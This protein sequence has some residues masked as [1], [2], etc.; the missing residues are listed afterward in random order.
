MKRATHTLVAGLAGLTLLVAACGDDAATASAVAVESDAPANGTGLRAVGR[1]A[2]APRAEH[3]AGSDSQ[4][5][6]SAPSAD[7]AE[8]W[9]TSRTDGCATLMSPDA[10]EHCLD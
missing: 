4:P 2:S 1:P 8:R 6:T 7:A 5:T 3:W 9:S 10:I